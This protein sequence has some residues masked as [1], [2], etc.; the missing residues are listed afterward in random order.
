MLPQ[1]GT[2]KSSHGR[3]LIRFPVLLVA[4]LVSMSAY[5]QDLSLTLTD[6]TDPVVA[7]DLLVYTMSFSHNGGANA[8]NVTVT[9]YDPPNTTLVNFQVLTGSG[10][11]A[12]FVPDPGGG[13]GGRFTKGTVASGETA[14]F[15]ITVRVDSTTPDGTI[16]NGAASVVADQADTNPGNENPTQQTTVSAEADLAVS[17]M[18]GAPDP[19]DAGNNLTYQYTFVN[20]GLSSAQN[21]TISQPV[22]ANTTFVSASVTTG[23][24]FSVSAPSVGSTGTVQFSKGTVIKN[25]GAVFQVVVKVVMAASG[26]IVSSATA[27]STTTDAAPGDE[28]DSATVAVNAAPPTIPII[29]VPCFDVAD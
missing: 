15:S 25:E 4:V 8:T 22:P 21:V 2:A 17:G 3:F 27:A 20:K 13:F 26:N 24:G 28:S 1:T 16:L 11:S 5:A 10:W 29:S 7:G 14:S 6:G 19:V 12:S 23:T 18:T 9:Q